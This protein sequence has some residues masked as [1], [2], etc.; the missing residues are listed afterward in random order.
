[1]R[2]W[3]TPKGEEVELTVNERNALRKAEWVL[4]ALAKHHGAGGV[5]SDACT[6]LTKVVEKWAPEPKEATNAKK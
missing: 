4:K 3:A 1:M 5:E 6:A 2:I